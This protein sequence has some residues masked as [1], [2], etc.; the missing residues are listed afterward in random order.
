MARRQIQNLLHGSVPMNMPIGGSPMGLHGQPPQ[1]PLMP[2]LMSG[3]IDSQRLDPHSGYAA[4]AQPVSDAYQDQ[5]NM[6][7]AQGAR[8]EK[9]RIH[10][11]QG[12]TRPQAEH[13]VDGGN[14]WNDPS[15][16]VP[17]GYDQ[18]PGGTLHRPGDFPSGETNIAYGHP[19]ANEG[20]EH[21]EDQNEKVGGAMSGDPNYH[22]NPLTGRIT[23]LPDWVIQ[24]R[25][26]R[27]P[28]ATGAGAKP[29]IGS[30]ESQR[31]VARDHIRAAGEQSSTHAPVLESSKVDG[32]S[33]SGVVEK[34]G[35]AQAERKYLKSDGTIG[36]I[37]AKPAHVSGY[38]ID[39]SSPHFGA[40]YNTKTHRYNPEIKRVVPLDA[41]LDDPNQN[42]IRVDTNA[43]IHKPGMT[44]EE[45][46]GNPPAGVPQPGGDP[47]RPPIGNPQPPALVPREEMGDIPPVAPI[48]RPPQPPQPP[49]PVNEFNEQEIGMDQVPN[50]RQPWEIEQGVRHRN[51]LDD[52][53]DREGLQWSQLPNR[54]LDKLK[55]Q[56]TGETEESYLAP[57]TQGSDERS[58]YSPSEWKHSTHDQKRGYLSNE[59]VDQI[60]G[61]GTSDRVARLDFNDFTNWMNLDAPKFLE[62]TY[63]PSWR[64][65]LAEQL[66]QGYDG[67]PFDQRKP[68]MEGP[69]IEN[70][71]NKYQP[72]F[73]DSNASLN[74]GNVNFSAEAAEQYGL[75]TM[76]LADVVNADNPL[77]SDATLLNKFRQRA[78]RN[79]A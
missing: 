12:M 37:P 7:A 70:L 31:R 53:K 4:P 44:P 26:N 35:F 34:M 50:D 41:P 72:G 2:G 73:Q 32:G 78:Q 47:T 69:M 48:G 15:L 25:Q 56:R 18:T 3:G 61:A 20:V 75:P 16:A 11:Q 5:A 77:M 58:G 62:E 63:G 6:L 66:G 74:Q 38:V 55:S 71:P 52:L 64:E 79:R 42:R 10:M 9:I 22:T 30:E 19:N 27:A 54:E 17:S 8:E 57:W 76:R 14:K 46:W 65:V 67:V 28:G 51:K 23:K 1:P 60:F 21:L 13:Y 68:L 33:G 39:E 29:E 43:P 49:A 45:R 24:N 40:S 59:G 36:I